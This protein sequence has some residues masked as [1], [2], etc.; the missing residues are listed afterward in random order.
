MYPNMTT[1]DHGFE[2]RQ[3][4]PRRSFFPFA[5]LRI[6]LSGLAGRMLE[7]RALELLRITRYDV[8]MFLL[9]GNL[10]ILFGVLRP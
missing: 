3:R 6:C 2:S 5:F 10:T 7:H 1:K 4:L 8:M 9:R